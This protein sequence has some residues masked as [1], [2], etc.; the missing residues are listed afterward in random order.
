[1]ERGLKSRLVNA[2]WERGCVGVS[3]STYKQRF[4]CSLK[5]IASTAETSFNKIKNFCTYDKIKWIV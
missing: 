5:M 4:Y 1:M 3:G 2:G